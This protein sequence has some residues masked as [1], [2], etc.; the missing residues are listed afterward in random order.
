M[1]TLGGIDPS[2]KG[3]AATGIEP[4]YARVAD[5]NTLFEARARRFA[6]VAD[7][8]EIGA[9]LTFLAQLCDVQARVAAAT[10]PPPLPDVEQAFAHGM[11]PLSR[12]LARDDGALAILQALLD[13]LAATPLADGP[14]AI[15]AGL[16][17]TDDA[18]RRRMLV[19][20]ADGLFEIERLGESALV[21]AALQVWYAFHA[22]QLDPARLRNIG[23]TICPACGGAPATSTIVGWPQAQN[24]RYLTCSLCQTMWNHVRVKCT[25]CGSTTTVSYRSIEGS[26]GDVGAEVCDS[27]RSYAKHFNQVKNPA[28]DPVADDVA[29]FGLDILLRE[30]GWRRAGLNPFLILP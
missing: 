25:T 19:A 27:C 10:V 3:Q 26:S 29:S 6:A 7:G 13:D 17:T 24:M 12:D 22:A 23:E 16:A 15:V 28:L 8:A 1:A 21:A 11:P 14:A 5:P 2:F 30:E 20:V 18:D 4:P 9:Y